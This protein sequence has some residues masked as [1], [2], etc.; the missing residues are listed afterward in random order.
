MYNTVAYLLY[1]LLVLVV[2]VYVGLYLYRNG[3][4]FLEQLLDDD[5]TAHAVNKFLFTGYCLVN[6]GGAFRCLYV[7]NE[8]HS[9]LEALAYVSVELGYLLLV[10]SV[11]HYINMLV[12]ALLKFIKHKKQI[13]HGNRVA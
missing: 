10:L 12:I 9:Y 8:F 13:S 1:L 6:A 5:T 7:A 2:V 3:R 11:M 4:Y